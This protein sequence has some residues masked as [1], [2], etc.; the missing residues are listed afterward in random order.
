M[1]IKPTDLPEVLLIEPDVYGDSRG[2]FMESWNRE[3]YAQLGFS[4]KFVQDNVS[5]SRRGVLRGLH[6]QNPKPQ[7]K[8]VS[9]L[10]GE[11][12]DVA[13]DIRS[14][15]PFFGRWIGINLSAENH[16]Q[17][18][19]PPGFAHGFYVLSESALFCYKCT[20]FYCSEGD[21]TLRWDDPTLAIDW[22][23]TDPALSAKDQGGIW[24]KDIPADALLAYS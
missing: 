5:F 18:Y 15:S 17:L 4:H 12:Y 14:G 24:L 19:I 7:G 22:P 9:V 23:T 21:Y 8:L 3:R 13:V 2:F 10:Y 16:L 20:D 1:K 11:V 6:F